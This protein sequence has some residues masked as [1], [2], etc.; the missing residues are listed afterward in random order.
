[1]AGQWPFAGQSMA[2]QWPFNGQSM[3]SQWPVHGQPMASNGH[4][5]PCNGQWPSM[6]IFIAV[7][8]ARGKR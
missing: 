3:A 8:F 7:K 1:M 2:T 6:A 5:W 4:H